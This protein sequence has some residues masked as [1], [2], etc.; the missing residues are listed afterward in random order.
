MIKFHSKTTVHNTGESHS[1]SR[2]A[3]F[4][5]VLELLYLCFALLL[6]WPAWKFI[7]FLFPRN[8]KIIVRVPAKLKVPE[9]KN[10]IFISILNGKITI[11]SDRCTHLGCTLHYAPDMN[12]YQC[13]CHGSR[14]DSKGRRIA[15]PARTPMVR[16]SYAKDEKGNIIVRIPLSLE[17]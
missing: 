4:S 2:R 8:K 17:K 15:G 12:E 9:H 16:L 10:G 3:L 1:R 6:F 14:F 11:F 13:P 7:T 5:H